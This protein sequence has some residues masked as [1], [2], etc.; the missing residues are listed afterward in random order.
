MIDIT[1]LGDRGKYGGSFSS[2]LSKP[3]FTRL[4]REED[5][6]LQRAEML[7]LFPGSNEVI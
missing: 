3:S 4:I 7:V 5:E 1:R 6:H 2:F